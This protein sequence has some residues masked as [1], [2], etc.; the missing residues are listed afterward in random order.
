MKTPRTTFLQLSPARTL[1]IAYSPLSLNNIDALTSAS[2]TCDTHGRPSHKYH[3][4]ASAVLYIPPPTHPSLI[5]PLRQAAILLHWAG[6]LGTPA[7][8][9]GPDRSREPIGERDPPPM[10]CAL[11]LR[12]HFRPCGFKTRKSRSNWSSYSLCNSRRVCRRECQARRIPIRI[13]GST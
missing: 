13:Q 4:T 7:C 10:T 12:R 11:R 8:A 9:L 2:A 1:N 6:P 3:V 5:T